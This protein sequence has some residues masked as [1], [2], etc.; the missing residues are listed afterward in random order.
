[1]RPQLEYCIQVWGSQQRKDVELLERVQRRAIKI[2]QGLECLCCKGRLKEPSLFR[3]QKRRLRGDQ[4]DLIE[5]FQYLKEI[6]KHEG[7]QL[8]K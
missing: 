4:G 1:M 3:L 6:C 5:A 8:S 2:I 7:N